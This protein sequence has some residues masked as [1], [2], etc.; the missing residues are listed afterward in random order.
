MVEPVAGLHHHISLSLGQ[1]LENDEIIVVVDDDAAIR[2]PLRCCFEEHRLAVAECD[3]GA[4]LMWLLA[5]RNVALIL[6]D[7]GLPDTDGVSLLPQIIDLHP[8]VA[9]VML[10]GVSDLSV[11]L[12]CLRKGATDYLSKPVQ[13]AEI[14]H[15]AR[16]ALEKRRLILENRKYQ[17]ELEEAHFR[18][19]LLHQL[20]IKMNTVYLSTVELDEILRAILV[21]ITAH[22]GLGF[23]RAFLAV[24]EEGGRL[25]K[26]RMAIGPSCREE[27]GKIWSEMKERDMNF[28]QI[29]HSIRD[30]CGR[31]DTAVN[32]IVRELTVPA[33]KEENILIAASRLRHSIAVSPANGCVP[34]V[35][36]RKRSIGGAAW[37]HHEGES[38]PPTP[39]GL[40]VPHD[41]I[42]LLGEDSFVVV[43]LYSPGQAFGVIIADNYVTRRPILDSHIS[44]LELF[45]SQASLAIE[46]SH[47][48]LDMQK[49]IAELQALYEELDKNKDQLVAAERYS[50]IGQMA[51]QLVHTIRNPITSIGGVSRILA[52][53][54]TDEGWLK[55]LNVII[56]ETAR[57]E[58][59]LEELFDFVSEGALQKEQVFLCSLARKTLLLLQNAMIKQG[60][61]WHL[62]CP[63]PEPIVSADP[64]QLRQVLLQ[65]FKNGIEAMP[66]GGTLSVSVRPEGNW[67]EILVHDTGVGLAESQLAKAK[68]PF[69]TTKTYGTGMG[70]T[71]VEK[72]VAAHGGEFSLKTREGDGMEARV[73]L[74]TG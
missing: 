60:V 66:E 32:R 19:Q 1:L 36:E 26:G 70:L 14:F 30:Q 47:M 38:P 13:L 64:R 35:L 33:T 41:L 11:A 59:T 67:V 3:N 68:D 15:V 50:A 18:I 55:Y 5:N 37:M 44:S 23:N 7:I 63:E 6:L 54:T 24:F 65:L 48:Y 9:V 42:R 28:L 61:A 29:V 20:S 21:G 52:K 49:K 8:D 71:L 74:P 46:Q 34:L 40:A 27:A 31:D 53:K 43:P 51:A 56:R 16:K 4:D 22:E 58:S 2:E 12:D 10:T 72:A 73:R 62:D 69:F 25:L 39:P 57:L 45:A 17:A